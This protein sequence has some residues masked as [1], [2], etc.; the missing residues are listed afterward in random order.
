MVYYRR[1]RRSH[2]ALPGFV[3]ITTGA[4]KQHFLSEFILSRQ[5]PGSPRLGHGVPKAL[6]LLGKDDDVEEATNGRD[7]HLDNPSSSA[8]VCHLAEHKKL[9]LEL[10]EGYSCSFSWIADGKAHY[11]PADTLETG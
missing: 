4:H 6:L 8:C 10:V 1:H 5:R 7:T 2:S 3:A 11:I 9:Q